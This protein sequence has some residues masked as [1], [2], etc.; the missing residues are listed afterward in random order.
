MADTD[1]AIAALGGVRD[2]RIEVAR[3]D[4]GLTPHR[5]PEGPME[6][7][8]YEKGEEVA[9]RTA[10]GEAVTALGGARG[11]VVVLDG[12]V[13]DS[14]RAQGFA[15][16]HPERFVECYIA[17]QQMVAAAVGLQVR[18]WVP[19]AATFAAF[20]SRA[21]DFIRMAAISRADLNL[22]GSHAGVAIGA[23]GPSQM[24][25]ED[26]ASLRA[27]YGSTVLH[28]CDAT[29]TA[30][31]TA[32]MADRRG[33]SYLRT[34]RGK[35]PVLY[36]PDEQFEIGGSTVLRSSDSDRVTVVAAGVTVHEAL[37]AADT[38]AEEGI[39][40]RVIDAYSI[41]PVDAPALRAA[42]ADTGHLLTVED[43]WPEGGLGDAVLDVFADSRP[44]P[45]MMKLA[46][47]AMPGSA[48][49]E[50]QLREAGIDAEA[51]AAAARGLLAHE[52]VPRARAHV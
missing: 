52:Q 34:M 39:A 30:A 9:T 45:R 41:K 51:I 17:E 24:G 21:Y 18:G 8:T 20:L 35:T 23:D 28:P 29:S 37:R 25:L 32:A 38:L 42:A 47:W 49:P 43:H 1:E 5:F 31:L 44:S 12:E 27:V 3:P 2:L 6:H 19:Y 15:D 22:V 13:A 33:V 50:E 40:V 16:A 48:T 26:I 46:V 10:F 4:P 14:T 7:R 11:D 36:G